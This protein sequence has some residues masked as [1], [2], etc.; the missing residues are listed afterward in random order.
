MSR[1]DLKIISNRPAISHEQAAEVLF[2]CASLLQMAGANEYRIAHYRQAAR[3]LLMLGPVALEMALDE[4]AWPL[5]GLGKRLGNKVRELVRDGSMNFY[6]ELRADLPPAVDRLMNVAG[7]GPK[8]ATRLHKELGVETPAQL[9][10]AARNGQVVKL[11][12]FGPKRQAA[13]ARIQGPTPPTAP[14]LRALR[15]TEAVEQDVLPAAA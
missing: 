3:T 1:Q 4:E 8:L 14:N 11:R 15:P 9:A 12:G 6:V 10:E 5:L 2:N 7:V 13:Y